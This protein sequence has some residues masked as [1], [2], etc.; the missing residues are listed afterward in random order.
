MAIAS[1]CGKVALFALAPHASS[2]WAQLMHVTQPF[3]GSSAG[4]RQVFFA[5]RCDSVLLCV[6]E[7]RT[8]VAT[9]VRPLGL[10]AHYRALA[11]RVA[12]HEAPVA[13]WPQVTSDLL[14]LFFFFQHF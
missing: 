1:A 13:I 7:S 8:Q 5:A 9:V 6:D 2:P 4:V 12:P 10:R 11:W 3:Q 14:V